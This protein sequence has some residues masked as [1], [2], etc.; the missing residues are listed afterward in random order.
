MKWLVLA[1]PIFHSGCGRAEN[2]GTPSHTAPIP[3]A[4]VERAK[5]IVCGMYVEKATALKADFDNA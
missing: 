5:D 4:T 3:A 1:V 2:P